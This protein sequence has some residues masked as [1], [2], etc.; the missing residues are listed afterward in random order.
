[1][2]IRCL[3]QELLEKVHIASRA[4]STKSV[5]PILSGIKI[6]A[7]KTIS[8][9]ATDLEM[10]IIT[11]VNGDIVET[12]ETVAPARLLV[13]ILKSLPGAA[14]VVKVMPEQGSVNIT[15]QNAEFDI[16][17]LSPADFPELPQI[18][19]AR[20]VALK[21][22]TFS[23]L[24]RQVVRAAS[25]D[26][27]RAVLTGILLHF[28]DKKIKMVATDSYRLAVSQANIDSEVS[29]EE[30]IVPAKAITEVSRMQPRENPKDSEPLLRVAFASNQMRFDMNGHTVITRLISGKYPPYQQ[31]IPSGYTTVI[32]LPPTQLEET[33]RRIAT[34]AQ[35]NT[36]VRFFFTPNRLII[37]ASTRE[38]G[39]AREEVPIQY[40]GEDRE[41]AFNPTFFLDGLASIK[42]EIVEFKMDS[43]LKPGLLKPRGDD[44]FLYLIMPVR[45]G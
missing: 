41:I 37:S 14:V 10:S 44:N 35:N 20:T 16:R 18:T 19:G 8:L 30:V 1:M 22:S 24:A 40:S 3:K 21:L 15:C 13:D 9:I 38:V 31:L 32:E 23:H 33:V 43:A 45:T 12:G 11:Q 4:I 27:A 26:E 5:L 36:P 7:A 25:T 34:L 2:E 39:Q 42:E 29:E 17:V 6:T 28:Q